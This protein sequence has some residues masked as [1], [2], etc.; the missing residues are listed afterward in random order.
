MLSPALRTALEISLIPS[1]ALRHITLFSFHASKR[2]LFYTQTVMQECETLHMAGVIN[3][4]IF[5][6]KNRMLESGL[7][8]SVRGVPS[9]GHPYRDP[10]PDADI[11]SSPK[12]V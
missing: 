6:G 3:C 1:A 12:L 7:S 8:G 2:I 11:R 9:N 5:R 10:G 4:G